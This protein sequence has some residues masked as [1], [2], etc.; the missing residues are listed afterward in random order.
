MLLRQI[1]IGRAY[2]SRTG[3]AAGAGDVDEQGNVWFGSTSWK[4]SGNYAFSF[5]T[6]LDFPFGFSIVVAVVVVDVDTMRLVVD[7]VVVVYIYRY[8]IERQD[9]S[10]NLFNNLNK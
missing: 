1:K 6:Q 7:G 4:V 9:I 10:I 8:T 3:V 2:K 5:A